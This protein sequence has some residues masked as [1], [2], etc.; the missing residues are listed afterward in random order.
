MSVHLLS[1]CIFIPVYS[2]RCVSRRRS[3]CDAPTHYKELEER[4]GGGDGRRGRRREAES[5][6]TKAPLCLLSVGEGE[7]HLKAIQPVARPPEDTPTF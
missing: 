2:C 7:G 1:C 4:G 5:L 3:P 6:A